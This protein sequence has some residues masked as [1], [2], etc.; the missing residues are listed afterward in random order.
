MLYTYSAMACNFSLARH[1]SHPFH[2]LSE[3]KSN[4]FEPGQIEAKKK[5]ET[6]LYSNKIILYYSCVAW[7]VNGLACMLEFESNIRL[8]PTKTTAIR[9]NTI[10]IPSYC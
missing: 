1:I 8:H 5:Q 4:F 6:E 7:L 3:I 9:L 2:S 10:H